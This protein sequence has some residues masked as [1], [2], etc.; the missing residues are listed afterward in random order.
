[1]KLEIS[2]RVKFRADFDNI[3]SYQEAVVKAA[4]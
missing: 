4:C 3:I 2:S 1:M